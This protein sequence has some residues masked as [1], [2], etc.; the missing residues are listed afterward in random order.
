MLP[1]CVRCQNRRHVRVPGGEWQRCE[2]LALTIN[3]KPVLRGAALRY[4]VEYD[5]VPPYPLRDLTVGGGGVAYAA[6]D[7][8]HFRYMVWRSLLVQ[9]ETLHYEYLE[10]YRVVDMQ[11]GKDFTYDNPRD[12]VFPKLVILTIGLSELPNKMLAPL[13]VQV[14]T[15]RRFAGLPTWVFTPMPTVKVRDEFG[16]ALAETLGTPV[17]PLEVR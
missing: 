14:L 11:F 8:R 9:S 12:L 15:G 1:N 5:Q 10:A 3:I 13:L 17:R 16:W 2:C 7:M 6:E 4:P